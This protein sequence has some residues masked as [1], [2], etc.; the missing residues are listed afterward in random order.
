MLAK[1]SSLGL[2]VALLVVQGTDAV[3]DGIVRCFVSLAVA[4]SLELGEDLNDDVERLV[5]N[6]RSA[7]QL[8]ANAFGEAVFLAGSNCFDRLR[9]KS[10]DEILSLGGS[11]GLALCLDRGDQV[12]AVLDDDCPALIFEAVPVR[13]GELTGEP[14]DVSRILGEHVSDFAPGVLAE[15]KDAPVRCV[16]LGL[17][18]G[19]DASVLLGFEALDFI[20]V[21]IGAEVIPGDL[22]RLAKSLVPVSREVLVKN[23]FLL[24]ACSDPL[25]A[26]ALCVARLEHS[27]LERVETVF[28][29]GADE[30]TVIF[31]G[32]IYGW[33]LMLSALLSMGS[34]A[35]A[36]GGVNLLFYSVKWDI[37]DVRAGD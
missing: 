17:L 26:A 8:A 12:D 11:L 3:P 14:F 31:H 13:V 18:L 30:V 28:V 23:F 1:L 5:A 24:A 20:E 2:V 7:Q 37:S 6:G 27:L 34:I 15:L 4:A 22:L 9:A 36:G 10:G 33:M 32:C 21:K 19:P 16:E 35:Y 29:P 25:T